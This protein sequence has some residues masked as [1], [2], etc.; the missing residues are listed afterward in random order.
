MT[1]IAT[2]LAMLLVGST[3]GIVTMALVVAGSSRD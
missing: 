1:L 2:H 3:L